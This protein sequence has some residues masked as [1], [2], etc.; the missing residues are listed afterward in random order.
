MRINMESWFV[1]LF[2]L[3]ITAI[4][5]SCEGATM[6]APTTD[7]GDNSTMFNQSSTAEPTTE[8]DSTTNDIT[9]QSTNYTTST[10]SHNTTE[11]NGSTVQSTKPTTPPE[12]SSTKPVVLTTVLTT[13]ANENCTNNTC[14]AGQFDCPMTC[15]CIEEDKICD[16]NDD[17]P[18]GSDEFQCNTTTV[19]PSSVPHCDNETQFFCPEDGFCI[20]KTKVDDGVIDCPTDC[21]DEKNFTGN[22]PTVTAIPPS[23]GND[24][25]RIV[26]ASFAVAVVLVI[27]AIS[28]SFVLSKK[29]TG[30]VNSRFRRLIEDD[31]A[32]QNTES[33]LYANDPFPAELNTQTSDVPRVTILDD[34][35]DDDFEGRVKWERGQED[36]NR[37][38]AD[39]VRRNESNA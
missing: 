24:V 5:I 39:T 16:G 7:S 15:V 14:P 36:L 22:C 13:L 10:I 8:D 17:C 18:D 26:I 33:P 19:E 20:N 38:V 11:V 21:A 1:T 29:R 12:P 6:L 2:I 30:Q 32:T 25:T 9:T 37:S 3:L 34:D 27:A 23:D 28:A 35:D 31:N 4:C